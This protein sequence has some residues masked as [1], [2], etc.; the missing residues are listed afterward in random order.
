MIEEALQA[1]Q[2]KLTTALV[3]NYGF[4][5]AGQLDRRLKHWSVVDVQPALFIV[6]KTMDVKQN[7]KEPPAIWIHLDLVLYV[8][9][10]ADQI[11][12]PSVIY[13]PIIDAIFAA[14]TPTPAG[15]EQNLSGTAFQCR[16]QGNIET[17]EGT[18]EDQGY[19]IIPLII[20]LP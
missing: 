11:L 20:I 10:S 8:K 17:D 1:L 12:S 5:V 16:I 19:V 6:Q 7:D 15:T 13:N 2:A 3:G 14:L 9:G 18:L 4:V